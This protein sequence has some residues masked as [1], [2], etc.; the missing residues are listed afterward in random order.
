[1]WFAIRR[2]LRHPK[3]RP[4]RHHLYN[5]DD[6]AYPPHASF[7]RWAFRNDLVFCEAP[8]AQPRLKR[9]VVSRVYFEP[10]S[11]DSPSN[12]RRVIAVRRH[13]HQSVLGKAECFTSLRVL[14]V[15]ARSRDLQ[16]CPSL[17]NGWKGRASSEQDRDRGDKCPFRRR[18]SDTNISGRR[19]RYAMR[20]VEILRPTP[21]LPALSHPSAPRVGRRPKA[22]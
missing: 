1:L 9:A 5:N 20:N 17:Q 7:S 16:I 14:P 19:C 6:S 21:I 10:R 18:N 15:K 3:T 4:L 13:V 2:I 22:C 12:P 8:S 11:A